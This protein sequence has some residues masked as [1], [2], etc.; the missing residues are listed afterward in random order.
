MSNLKPGKTD[1]QTAAQ[2][3]N[4]KGGLKGLYEL[5]R[6][7]DHFDQDNQ[8]RYP[9]IKSGLFVLEPK[10][11]NFRGGKGFRDYHKVWATGNG[12]AWLKEVVRQHGTTKNQKA[13]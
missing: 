10:R 11:G 4:I 6:K 9:L 7:L 13:A 3:T 2:I 1:M 12:L 5:L 8:P